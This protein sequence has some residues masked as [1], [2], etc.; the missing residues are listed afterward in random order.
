MK[1]C[2]ESSK[3][4]SKMSR[5]ERRQLGVRA[6]EIMYPNGYWTCRSHGI[7]EYNVPAGEACSVCNS[8]NAEVSRPAAE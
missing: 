8:A 4:M 6:R 5:E 1:A 2:D 3:R 7:L